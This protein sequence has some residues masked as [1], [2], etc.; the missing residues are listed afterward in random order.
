[1]KQWPRMTR[2]QVI[3]ITRQ[4][5]TQAL[6]LFGR[7]SKG[8]KRTIQCLPRRLL[9]TSRLVRLTTRLFRMHT[10][11]EGKGNHQQENTHPENV[12]KRGSTAREIQTKRRRTQRLLLLLLLLLLLPLLQNNTG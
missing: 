8:G 5:T 9:P 11:R 2:K 4:P 6:V 10:P 7:D 3:R 12:V 1:M